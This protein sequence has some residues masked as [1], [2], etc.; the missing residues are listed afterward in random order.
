MSFAVIACTYV[1][2]VAAGIGAGA[3]VDDAHPLWVAGVGMVTGARWWGL[4][5]F[6]WGTL[7]E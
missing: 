6:E 5:A 2:A 7:R 4:W 1:V 3:L